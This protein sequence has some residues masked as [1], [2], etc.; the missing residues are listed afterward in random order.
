MRTSQV[1]DHIRVHY[2]KRY[3]DGAVRSSRDGDGAP[4]EVT[5]GTRHPRLPWLGEELIGL[6]AGDAPRFA[7]PADRA[8]GPTDPARVRSVSRNRFAADAALAPG[9]RARM[10][11]GGGRA[12]VVKVVEVRGRVVVVDA[13]HPR[14]GQAV[15]LE[16]EVV[17]VE[18]AG[19]AAG[20]W[21]P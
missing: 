19:S 15:Q 6:T 13:N 5:V 2:V 10:R 14:C 4:L 17:A 16:V 7:I 3:A 12:R 20:H 8:F 1:G 18:A 11:L 9:G 21:G